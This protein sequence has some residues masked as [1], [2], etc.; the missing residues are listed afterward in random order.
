[1]R[2]PEVWGVKNVLLTQKYTCTVY[3]V[4]GIRS[5]S[6]DNETLFSPYFLT[7]ALREAQV[8]F[9]LGKNK[10]SLSGIF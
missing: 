10:V 6:E 8:L 1:M 4:R 7:L 3:E 9:E 2:N 5:F